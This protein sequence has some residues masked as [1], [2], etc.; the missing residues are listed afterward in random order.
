MTNGVVALLQ[1]NGDQRELVLV[2]VDDLID[3]E[4]PILPSSHQQILLGVHED[5]IFLLSIL[6]LYK[7]PLCGVYPEFPIETEPCGYEPVGEHGDLILEVE[8]HQVYLI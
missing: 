7:F 3:L 4:E 1:S 2:L 6:C 8:V 5:T